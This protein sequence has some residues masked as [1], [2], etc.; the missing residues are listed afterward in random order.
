M[1]RHTDPDLEIQ[2][3]RLYLN[4]DLQTSSNLWSGAFSRWFL[5]PLCRAHR[6][7][8]EART[9]SPAHRRAVVSGVLPGA[10]T[11]PQEQSGAQLCLLE[12][13]SRAA[14]HP[15]PHSQGQPCTGS[16]PGRGTECRARARQCLQVTAENKRPSA[17]V[18]QN[19]LHI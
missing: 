12:R 18:S 7:T 2:M 14:A 10:V 11:E 13:L 16:C 8:E 19:H 15:N 3:D 5:H 9:A 1:T 17:V 6:H 4:F